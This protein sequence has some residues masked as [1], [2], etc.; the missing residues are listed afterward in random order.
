MKPEAS[1]GLV[2]SPR[3]HSCPRMGMGAHTQ[4]CWL[5]SRAQQHAAPVS[6]RES[7]GTAWRDSRASPGTA[8]PA[9]DQVDGPGNNSCSWRGSPVL[10]FPYPRAIKWSQ[11][12]VI[13]SHHL[14][15]CFKL[16]SQLGTRETKGWSPSCN[17]SQMSLLHLWLGLWVW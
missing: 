12:R 15:L 11:P 3:P 7:R 6:W 14:T 10:R 1:R 16:L 8:G 5:L 2:S 17:C 4:P 9:L 13:D